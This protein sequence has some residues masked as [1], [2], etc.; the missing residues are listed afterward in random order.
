MFGRSQRLTGMYRK[1]NGT[2]EVGRRHMSFLE[3]L[4]LS[5][6]IEIEICI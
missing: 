1:R 5:L 4:V 3:A 2:E 6:Y